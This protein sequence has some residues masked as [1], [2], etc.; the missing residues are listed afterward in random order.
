MHIAVLCRCC[1]VWWRE[2]R[3]RV[4]GGRGL[5]ILSNFSICCISQQ[6]VIIEAS[7][8]IHF[9]LFLLSYN[10]QNSCGLETRVFLRFPSRRCSHKTLSSSLIMQTVRIA[11]TSQRKTAELNPPISHWEAANGCDSK[12]PISVKR[13]FT[14]RSRTEAAKKIN[15]RLRRKFTDNFYFPFKLAGPVRTLNHEYKIPLKRIHFIIY[16]RSAFGGIVVFDVSSN[17]PIFRNYN[18]EPLVHAD[19]W[20]VKI[21]DGDATVLGKLWWGG[22]CSC[23]VVLLPRQ[24]LLQLMAKEPLN[25]SCSSVFYAFFHPFQWVC[26]RVTTCLL[27]SFSWCAALLPSRS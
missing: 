13:C 22:V 4:G 24:H 15:F 18:R 11:Q 17:V 3:R 7:S 21:T 20:T 26:S 8:W 2:Y 12:C 14:Y 5:W 27:A 25:F 16:S 23:R 9:F 1:I 19:V 10:F 6:K